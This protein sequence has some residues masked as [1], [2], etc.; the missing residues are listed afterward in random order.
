MLH[1]LFDFSLISYIAI[2]VDQELYLGAIA[3]ILA[4]VIIAIVVI[5]GRKRRETAAVR[6]AV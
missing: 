1:G 5:I 2:V 4:Y 3:G 6:R